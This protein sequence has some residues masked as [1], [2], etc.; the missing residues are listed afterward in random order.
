M[1]GARACDHLRDLQD[2]AS[3]AAPA[4]PPSLR[5]VLISFASPHRSGGTE[6]T[7]KQQVLDRV[8]RALVRYREVASCLPDDALYLPAALPA[9]QHPVPLRFGQ[10]PAR[11]VALRADDG[12]TL[13]AELTA[14]PLVRTGLE[15]SHCL[16]LQGPAALGVY[17]LADAPHATAGATGIT[18]DEHADG[19]TLTCEGRTVTFDRWNGGNIRAWSVDGFAPFASVGGIRL[20]ARWQDAPVLDEVDASFTVSHSAAG[21]T[22]EARLTL[23]DIVV[24]KQWEMRDGLTCCRHSVRLE[25]RQFSYLEPFAY[26]LDTAAFGEAGQVVMVAEGGD[27]VA[28]ESMRSPHHIHHL[29]ASLVGFVGAGGAAGIAVN[30]LCASPILRRNPWSGQFI[31]MD[32]RPIGAADNAYAYT[33]AETPVFEA[34]LRVCPGGDAASVSGW[35]TLYTHPPVPAPNLSP[36]RTSEHLAWTVQHPHISTVNPYF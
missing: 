7:V 26:R 4:L 2:L 15:R 24:V 35:Q 21:I 22:V 6:F 19:L 34:V 23:E 12:P 13:A 33:F 9:G 18:V 17:R 10:G 5:D 32:A 25:E 16:W 8:D 14:A 27:R 29:G 3:D 31:M 20:N 36:L 1:A 30:R 11:P 28:A